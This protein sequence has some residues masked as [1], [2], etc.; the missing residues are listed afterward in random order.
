[1]EYSQ[2]LLKAQSLSG[3]TVIPSTFESN[4][5]YLFAIFLLLSI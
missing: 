5:L 1:M 3:V 2:K 4:S